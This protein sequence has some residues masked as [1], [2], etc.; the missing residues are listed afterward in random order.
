M[1]NKNDYTIDDLF[2][3]WRRQSDR[4]DKLVEEHPVTEVKLPPRGRRLSCHRRM[5]VSSLS[6]AVLCMV[7]LVWLVCTFDHYVVD[8]LDLVPH[9]LVGS[10]LLYG[11]VSHLRTA[12]LLRRYDIYSTPPSVM[13]RFVDRNLAGRGRD[14]VPASFFNARRSRSTTLVAMVAL[15]VIAVTPVYDGRTM[16]TAGLHD[17]IGTVAMVNHMI[18]DNTN[19][20][21]S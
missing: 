8:T 20:L 14:G 2:D 12:I 4:I 3:A 18:S 17:R 1:N 21:L 6:L 5:L 7:A 9:L 11:V 10:L 15:L 13:N 19:N 16:S